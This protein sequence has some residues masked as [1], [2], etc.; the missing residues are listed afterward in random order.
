MTSHGKILKQMRYAIYDFD[1]TLLQAP[2][3]PFILDQW[4]KSDLPK[5]RFI[6]IKRK[7]QFQYVL[8]RLR[9]FGVKREAFRAWAMVQV[10]RLFASITL[11]AL[12]N[13]LDQ[14]YE[15]S[16]PSLHK[17]IVK[18]IKLDKQAGFTTILLSGN[19]DI[20]LE[21]YRTHG[22][23]YILGTSLFNEQGAAREKIEIVISSKKSE[24]ILKAIPQIRWDQTK[25]YA[26][27]I[28]DLPLLDL[29]KEP[30]CVTPDARLKKHAILHHWKIIN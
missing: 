3:V 14:L 20:F 13:F 15:A 2:T 19:Y 6:Q 9:V 27:S 7:I 16:L 21:R 12:S 17:K 26:D 29:V 25:A 4:K 28:Y 5:D 11:Q 24:A 22:F 8:Y 23:D 1:G 10:G 18:Q 30:I